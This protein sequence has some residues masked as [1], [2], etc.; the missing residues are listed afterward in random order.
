MLEILIRTVQ[1][2]RGCQSLL[3]RIAQPSKLFEI[4]LRIN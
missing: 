2:G 1:P 3:F 4:Q